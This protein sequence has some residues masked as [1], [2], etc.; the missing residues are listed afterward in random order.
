MSK[1][2]NREVHFQGRRQ[3]QRSVEEPQTE[4]TNEIPRASKQEIRHLIEKEGAT[5]T[6]KIADDLNDGGFPCASA[7]RWSAALVD[8]ALRRQDMEDLKSSIKDNRGP[9]DESG[10][11]ILEIKQAVDDTI[12]DAFKEYGASSP[13]PASID[14]FALKGAVAD[15]MT[16]T[17]G[18]LQRR[19]EEISTDTTEAVVNHVREVVKT[20]MEDDVDMASVRR[21]TDATG[22]NVG[23]ICKKIDDTCEELHETVTVTLKEHGKAV[24]DA[25]EMMAL[26]LSSQVDKRFDSLEDTLVAKLVTG[27]G[28]DLDAVLGRVIDVRLKTHL[29]EVMNRLAVMVGNMKRDLMGGAYSRGKYK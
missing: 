1:P 16:Q 7:D 2:K 25:C 26:E 23:E 12:R 6:T 20:V 3:S 21:V 28:I 27:K 18:A 11:S 19:M 17:L 5:S 8:S 14:T 15:A 29:D 4:S 22:H 13:S 9:E 24:V 10:L